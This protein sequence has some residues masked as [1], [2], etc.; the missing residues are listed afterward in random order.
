MTL[1]DHPIIQPSLDISPIWSPSSVQKQK[2][3]NSVQCRLRGE[4]CVFGVG[5]IQ[6]ICLSSDNFN[7]NSSLVQRLTCVE[8]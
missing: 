4:S 5:T 1:I 8:F 7:S 2:N 3:Y 6:R